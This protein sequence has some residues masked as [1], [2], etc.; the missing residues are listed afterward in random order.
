MWYCKKCRGTEKYESGKCIACTRAF[1]RKSYHKNP[2]K[3]KENAKEWKRK[4]RERARISGRKGGRTDW[5]PGEHERA[6]QRL[7]T[8]TNC[9]VCKGEDPRHVRGWSADHNHETGKFRG[10]VCHPCNMAISHV[11]KY[12]LDRGIQISAYLDR[13]NL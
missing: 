10:M 3:Y 1:S 7:L 2:E 9:G 6:E 5:L 12:G 4:N 11:E 8:V 13:T